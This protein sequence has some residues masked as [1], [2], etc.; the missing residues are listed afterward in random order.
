MVCITSGGTTVPLEQRCV[1]FIDNAVMASAVPP[2]S[3]TQTNHALICFLLLCLLMLLWSWSVHLL[4]QWRSV[5]CRYFLKA[6][7]P[8]IFIHRR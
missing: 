4:V 3:S 1:R 2:P 5:Q 8:V 6:G 7:Y